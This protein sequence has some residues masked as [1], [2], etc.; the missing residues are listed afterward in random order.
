M[1]YTIITPTYQRPQ[2]LL[3]A[4]KS[5]QSQ[6]HDNWHMVI[7]N[8]SP[9]ADYSK[10]KDAITN[11]H[12][13]IYHVNETN[14]GNNYSKNVAL[15]LLPTDTD[16]IVFLD[17]DDWF[18]SQALTNIDTY[19][20]SNDTAWLIT[21]RILNDG[22]PL[23]RASHTLHD[24]V[25]SYGYSYLFGKKISGDAT[26]CVHKD[27]IISSNAHFSKHVA[28]GEEWFFFAQLNTPFLYT[29]LDTT[30][31]DGYTSD[32]LNTYMQKTYR[33]NTRQLWREN[34]KNSTIWLYLL[35]RTIRNI[36]TT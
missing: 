3:R 14:S 8:D 30:M 34:N 15:S 2:I 9:D 19:L 26:H 29:P 24:R 13:I 6:S 35:F 20:C 23:T 5:V 36:I 18:A 10:I 22:S 27:L 25:T 1:K 33:S 21:N 31:S 12:R 32:G 11:D 7:I 28:N 16:Y 17:D 4:I